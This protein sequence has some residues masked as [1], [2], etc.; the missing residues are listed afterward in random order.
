MTNEH[1]RVTG[2]STNSEGNVRVNFRANT[3]DDFDLQ[4]FFVVDG[5]EWMDMTPRMLNKHLAEK[6]IE[7]GTKEKEFW[8]SK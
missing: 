2:T 6:L 3:I 8:G 5:M 1:L 4:G 7:Y